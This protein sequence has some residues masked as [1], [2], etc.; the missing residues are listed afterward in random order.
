MYT[1]IAYKPRSSDYCR[2]CHMASYSDDHEIHNFYKRQELI[3]A[4]TKYLHK[5][6]NLRSSEEGYSFWLFKNG[7]KLYEEN[8][9]SWDGH[10]QYEYDSPEYWA[11]YDALEQQE[12]DDIAELDEILRLANEKAKEL[13]K[14]QIDREASAKAAE[15][16]RQAIRDREERLKKFNELQKEFGQ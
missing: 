10:N 2:G 7:I 6:M 4:W 11:N 9:Q 15:R 1:F 14:A 12:K 5:N 16:A 3:E 13:N 8:H